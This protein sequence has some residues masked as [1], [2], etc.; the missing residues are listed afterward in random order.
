MEN[1][2]SEIVFSSSN[3]SISKQIKKMES[4]GKL[5]KIAPRIYTSNLVESPESIIKRN[6]FPILA[7]LYPD[8]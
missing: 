6:I 7:H 1:I 3:P 4:Q 8:A 5:I 2:L